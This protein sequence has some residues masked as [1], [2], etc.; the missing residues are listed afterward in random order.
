MALYQPTFVGSEIEDRTVVLEGDESTIR[1]VLDTLTSA[2]MQ[3]AELLQQ[4]QSEADRS[5]ASSLSALLHK[6]R[7][8]QLPT[9]DRVEFWHHPEKAGWMQSQGEHIPTW[10]R[11]WFVLKQ[12]FLFRFSSPDVTAASKPRGVLDLSRV[13]DV[14]EGLPQTGRQN[15][16]LVHTASGS[17]SYLC[18]SETALVEWCSA[19]EGAVQ[20]IVKIVAGVEEDPPVGGRSQ[21]RGRTSAAGADDWVAQLQERMDRASKSGGAA[22][23]AKR[24]EPATRAQ[25]QQ[26]RDSDTIRIVNYAPSAAEP[27]LDA[28]SISGAAPVPSQAEGRGLYPAAQAWSAESFG[29]GASAEGSGYHNAGPA[30]PGYQMG[31]QGAQGGY[32]AGGQAYQGVGGYQGG[33][34]GQAYASF[35]GNSGG[36]AYP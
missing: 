36:Q 31:A 35:Q 15:S 33:S 6:S 1:S 5:A 20:R 22:G 11:R 12:G 8:P 3:T 30:S 24:A 29:R 23:A 32:A 14:C 27:A 2:C 17:V 13:T 18:D 26:P 19:L 10:R 28:R 25:Q 4:R 21:S 34:G 16:L 7:R 9:A